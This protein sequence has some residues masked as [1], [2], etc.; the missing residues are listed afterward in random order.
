V[1]QSRRGYDQIGLRKGMARLAT[2]L[3]QEPPLEHDV[4]GDRQDTLLEHR[5]YLVREPIVLDSLLKGQS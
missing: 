1:L 3:H 5:P 4:F 2:I